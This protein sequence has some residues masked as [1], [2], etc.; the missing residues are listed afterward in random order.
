MK[1][2]D[3]PKLFCSFSRECREVEQLLRDE[4][5]P[6]LDLGPISELRKPY[7]RYGL[8]TFYGV[9]GARNFIEIWKRGLSPLA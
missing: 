9:A 8:S 6:Y 3:R 7:I 5:I 4:E 1:T 2:T